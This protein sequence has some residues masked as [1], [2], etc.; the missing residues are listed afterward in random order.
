MLTDLT[1]LNIEQAFELIC[2]FLTVIS[3]FGS[4]IFAARF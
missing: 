4:Y 1:T 2:V 3:A